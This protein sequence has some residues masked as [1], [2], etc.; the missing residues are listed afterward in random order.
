MDHFPSL[1]F[2]LAKTSPSSPLTLVRPERQVPPLLHVEP[3]LGVAARVPRNERVLRERREQLLPG[4][5]APG[6]KG[7]RH[8]QR[9]TSRTTRHR[10]SR[11]GRL[12]G[13]RW[14]TL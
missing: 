6:R 4:P 14:R 2:P 11:K 10:L 13:R 9:A 8:E 7:E 5:A 1:T 12:M 3:V